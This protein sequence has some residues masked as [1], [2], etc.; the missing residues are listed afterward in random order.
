MSH[1]SPFGIAYAFFWNDTELHFHIFDV[2]Y[3]I[4]L[5]SDVEP[6][7]EHGASSR[8]NWFDFQP[9]C[10]W[11]AF[12]SKSWSSSSLRFLICT[13]LVWESDSLTRHTAPSCP[14]P[15]RGRGVIYAHMSSVAGLVLLGGGGAKAIAT[16]PFY[17]HCLARCFAYKS[18]QFMFLDW[19]N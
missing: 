9:C 10:W 19:G 6:W 12:W 11:R 16:L 3:Y 8:R 1:L 5:K 4:N 13:E 2:S 17:C 18:C 7:Q 14:P 15:P